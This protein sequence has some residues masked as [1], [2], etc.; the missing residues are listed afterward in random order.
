[1]VYPGDHIGILTVQAFKDFLQGYFGMAAT[2]RRRKLRAAN[3]AVLS[4][5]KR[6]YA[7]GEAIRLLII[8]DK[9][10]TRISATVHVERYDWKRIAG[11]EQV[12]FQ[13]GPASFI[14]LEIPAPARPGGYRL[15]MDGSR[16]TAEGTHA[17]F[18]VSTTARRANQIKRINKRPAVRRRRKKRI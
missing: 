2:F 11:T 15:T 3:V 10:V 12:R 17:W 4:P 14:P 5:D 18:V 7:P 16:K 9:A 1:M 13:G 6:I 8:P